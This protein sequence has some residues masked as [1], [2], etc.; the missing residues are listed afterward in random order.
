[1]LAASLMKSIGGQGDAVGCEQAF[2]GLEQVVKG[3]EIVESGATDKAVAENEVESP[4]P[5]WSPHI[6]GK[7]NDREIGGKTLQGSFAGGGVG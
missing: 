3:G 5:G 1:M 7:K 6:G 4:A 2:H